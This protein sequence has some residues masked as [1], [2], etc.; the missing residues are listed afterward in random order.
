LSGQD[1][2]STSTPPVAA[3]APHDNA[4]RRDVGDPTDHQDF[5]RWPLNRRLKR[6]SLGASFNARD[7]CCIEHCPSSMVLGCVT[8]GGSDGG[9]G[10]SSPFG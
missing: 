5:A 3:N 8:G 7:K 4:R 2:N 9:K 10:A 6:W 1:A